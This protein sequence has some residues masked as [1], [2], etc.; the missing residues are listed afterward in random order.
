MQMS[1]PRSPDDPQVD[2]GGS[3]QRVNS[4]AAEAQRKNVENWFAF[5]ILN[6]HPGFCPVFSDPFHLHHMKS[7]TCSDQVRA[8]QDPL[9]TTSGLPQTQTVVKM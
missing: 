1:F 3:G 4:R 5:L 2:H 6:H 7:N 9:K 8:E